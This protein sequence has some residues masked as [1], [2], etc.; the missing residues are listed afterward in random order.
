MTGAEKGSLSSAALAQ[1]QARVHFADMQGAAAAAAA[2]EAA[3][4]TQCR[5]EGTGRR[6]CG[7]GGGVGSGCSTSGDFPPGGGGTDDD[8]EQFAPPHLGRAILAAHDAIDACPE[9]RALCTWVDAL[10]RRNGDR[11]AP[12]DLDL[13]N[14]VALL[15][16][17]A[18]VAPAVFS[19][20]HENADAADGA[21]GAGDGDAE[22][23]LDEDG[24][25]ARRNMVRLCR[26]LVRFQWT[27]PVT[28]RPL[29]SIDFDAVEPWA[30]GAFVV[31][32]ALSG[33]EADLHFDQINATS[34]KHR[35]LMDDLLTKA[36][37]ALKDA[38]PVKRPDP[39]NQAALTEN[40]GTAQPGIVVSDRKSQ[41][42]SSTLAAEAQK[43]SSSSPAEESRTSVPDPRAL[44]YV[45]PDSVSSSSEGSQ[46]QRMLP[47]SAI[48]SMTIGSVTS[49]PALPPLI[50]VPEADLIEQQERAAR[51]LQAQNRLQLEVPP[52]TVDKNT[53]LDIEPA[54]ASE[55]AELTTICES[56]RLR[57]A[58]QYGTPAIADNNFSVFGIQRSEV[59]AIGDSSDSDMPKIPPLS[60]LTREIDVDFFSRPMAFGSNTGPT[61]FDANDAAL[62][63]RIANRISSSAR[64]AL[65]GTIYCT[66]RE[67]GCEGQDA[68]SGSHRED[69]GNEE[70]IQRPVSIRRELNAGMEQPDSITLPLHGDLMSKT[71]KSVIGGD[72]PFLGI[73]CGQVQRI[74]AIASDLSLL[75]PCNFALQHEAQACSPVG[76]RS[77]GRNAQLKSDIPADVS[78]TSAQ[79][80]T[81]EEWGAYASKLEGQL[82]NAHQRNREWA[83]HAASLQRLASDLSS[84]LEASRAQSAK[85]R[86]RSSAEETSESAPSLS[87]QAAR[88]RREDAKEVAAMSHPGMRAE[89][90]AKQRENDSLRR[91]LA[92]SEKAAATLKRELE[93]AQLDGNRVRT[94][95][96]QPRLPGVAASPT[97]RRGL[98]R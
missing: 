18:I 63:Q 39:N 45:I 84:K 54:P 24:L 78:T 69:S 44:A 20:Q 3:A 27:D 82:E 12:I 1:I 70:N 73:Q 90:A 93:R 53:A 22:T 31:L 29:S 57:R 34:S 74:N 42:T 36:V 26:A 50:L 77:P 72:A 51:E 4:A 30:V 38:A 64:P 21:D 68:I 61:G 32:A 92:A 14:G 87:S 23:D 55:L 60:V 19:G 83:E 2:A 86:L 65:S 75:P 58:P 85:L 91:K 47:S 79:P 94:L 97:S 67:D 76:T 17:L 52:R 71:A 81:A 43:L 15:R 6:D 89:L 11:P 49:S 25:V 28:K 8:A 9:L 59:A 66:V 7:T 48:L 96:G 5:V 80:K 16:A 56:T 37:D 33:P 46:P 88:R 35:N 62:T 13:T 95:S 10:R 41:R 98:P 40:R